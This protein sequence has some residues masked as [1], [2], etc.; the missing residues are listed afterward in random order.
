MVE[1]PSHDWQPI[2]QTLEQ[3]RRNSCARLYSLTIDLHTLVESRQIYLVHSNKPV[4]AKPV[5][6]RE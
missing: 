5:G 2:L 6:V 3:Y 1:Q 4:A